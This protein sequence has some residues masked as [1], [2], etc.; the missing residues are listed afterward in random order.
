MS[1]DVQLKQNDLQTFKA[2]VTI[3]EYDP[4]YHTHAY[5]MNYCSRVQILVALLLIKFLLSLIRK[6]KKKESCIHSMM[7]AT[8][9]T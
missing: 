9:R 2:E 1:N 7:S 6:R 8:I 5:T 3:E 4:Q